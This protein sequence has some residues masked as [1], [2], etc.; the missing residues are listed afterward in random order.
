MSYRKHTVALTPFQPHCVY[1][2]THST[3]KV[4]S[5]K[6]LAVDLVAIVHKNNH[7]WVAVIFYLEPH[8]DH[9]PALPVVSECSFKRLRSPVASNMV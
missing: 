5:H 9:P 3:K 1:D 7:M 2:Y 4:G 8:T 6:R